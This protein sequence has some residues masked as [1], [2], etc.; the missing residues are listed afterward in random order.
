V[1]GDVSVIGLGK[2]GGSMAGC[3]ASRGFKVIGVDVSPKAVDALNAGRAPVQEPGLDD[4]VSGNRERIRATLSHEDAVRNSDLSFVI[5]PTPSDER[6]AFSLQY[7]AYAFEALGKALAKKDRYHTIVL[8]STVLPGS[9]RYGLLPILEEY[10]GKRCGRDFG[11]CYSPEFIAL[12]TVIRDFLNPDF[13]LI[14][15]FDERSGTT[16]HSVLSRVALNEAPARRM[17]IEN[18]E[19]AKIALNS[20]VTLKIS[21][22]NMLA[23]LCESIPG[24]NIDVV[25]DALGM[26]KRIGRRYLTGGFGYGGPCFPR[27]NVALGFLGQR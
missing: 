21:Y 3:L 13:F 27:D 24:G 4:L 23:E 10:S 5:V 6:G 15:E 9:T 25:S 22:A 16:L 1:I 14:G 8:T 17:S 12:G 7:A 11:L 26:D 20:Y 19:L 18:A 2:L